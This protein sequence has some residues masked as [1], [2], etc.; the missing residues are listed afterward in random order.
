MLVSIALRH[1]NGKYF[2]RFTT[3]HKEALA[4]LKANAPVAMNNPN[5]RIIFTKHKESN[6][7]ES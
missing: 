2:G 3:D 4:V 1:D 5:V 7:V 6:N